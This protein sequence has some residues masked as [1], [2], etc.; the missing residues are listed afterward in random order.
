[1]N[2]PVWVVKHGCKSLSQ[3]LNEHLTRVNSAAAA[4]TPKNQRKKGRKSRPHSRR[5]AKN[6]VNSWKTVKLF[7]RFLK[8]RPSQP[9]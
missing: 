5:A 6:G 8:L 3:N 4:Q 7:D 2:L 1:L 9:R